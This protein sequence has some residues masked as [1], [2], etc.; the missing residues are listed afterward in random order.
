MDGLEFLLS[1]K[2]KIQSIIEMPTKEDNCEIPHGGTAVNMLRAKKQASLYD[3]LDMLALIS[4]V[5]A[6][7]L[8]RKSHQT[9]GCGNI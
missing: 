4:F 1:E 8:T 5:P 6:N 9:L 3:F 2:E 7:N